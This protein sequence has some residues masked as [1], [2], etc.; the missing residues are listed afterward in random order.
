VC[1]S[2]GGELPRFIAGELQVK[3]NAKS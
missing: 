2:R 3:S 1:S